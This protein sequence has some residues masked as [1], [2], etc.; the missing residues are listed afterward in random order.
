[1]F[2]M[3]LREKFTPRGYGLR[4]LLIVALCGCGLAGASTA[5]DDA[6]RHGPLA[7]DLPVRG[8]T[9]LSSSEPD[10]LATIAAA[11]DFGINHIEL[12]HQIVAELRELRNDS[13]SALVNRL[14]DAAHQA[15]ISEVVL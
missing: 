15:G 2:H 3:H 1:M 13:K 4:A 12:S 5:V 11:P 7:S 9:I 6:R 14:I 10:A 8:W